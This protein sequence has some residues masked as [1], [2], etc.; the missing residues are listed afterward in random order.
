LGSASKD[1]TL[2][3]LGEPRQTKLLPDTR[4]QRWDQ[5]CRTLHIHGRHA[6]MKFGREH[7]AIF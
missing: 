5:T 7:N 3:V 6:L 2:R 1:S 4:W